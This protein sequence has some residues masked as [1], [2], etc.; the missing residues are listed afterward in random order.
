MTPEEKKLWLEYQMEAF[1]A[2][3]PEEQDTDVI[4]TLCTQLADAMLAEAK[5]KGAV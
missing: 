1:K 2:I 3:I 4:S 5:K